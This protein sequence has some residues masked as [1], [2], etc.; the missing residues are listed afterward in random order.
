MLKYEGRLDSFGLE[1]QSGGEE[2]QHRN[3][4]R[5]GSWYFSFP[6]IIK[7]KEYKIPWKDSFITYYSR[8]EYGFYVFEDYIN[9]KWGDQPDYFGEIKNNN[10]K[11]YSIPW[12]G[13]TF[14]YH[15]LF[16]LS[17]NELVT[18]HGKHVDR[19][20]KAYEDL[21]K[22]TFILK[23]FDDEEIEATCYIE[24]RRWDRGTKWCSWLKYFTEP[25]IRRNID[26][27][28]NKETGARKGSWKGGTIGTSEEIL[29]SEL[30]VEAIERYCTKHNMTYVGVKND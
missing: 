14:T 19:D 30:V 17:H 2:S 1:W 15:K 21:P 29:P 25:I 23:D 27:E 7:P 22:I 20:S 4:L 11:S 24:E 10:Y 28:F 5:I 13:Y 16:D 3:F 12:K 9:F 26:I 6:A 8:R 18:S